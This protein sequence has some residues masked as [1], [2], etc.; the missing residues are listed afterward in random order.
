MRNIKFT[1]VVAMDESR[2]IGYQGSLPWKLPRELFKFR[3]RTIGHPVLMGRKTWESLPKRPLKGRQN[4]VLTKQENY[5][6]EGAHVIHKLED[7]NDILLIHN[8]IMVIGGGE[9]Y[10]MMMPLFSKLIITHLDGF[11]NTDTAFPEY[12]GD[13]VCAYS[14]HRHG[15]RQDTYN[16]IKK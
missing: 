14:N 12:E 4:I 11:Y 6:T 3:E 7:L 8:E 2:G 5:N 9:I 15:Y 16:R 1:A 10:K 13:F